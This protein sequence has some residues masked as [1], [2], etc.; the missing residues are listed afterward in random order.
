MAGGA[1]WWMRRAGSKGTTWLL[2]SGISL[3]WCSSQRKATCGS[4]TSIR[5]WEGLHQL[6]WWSRGKQHPSIFLWSICIL[7]PQASAS[8]VLSTTSAGKADDWLGQTVF[9]KR[10]LFLKNNFAGAESDMGWS[11]KSGYFASLDI[12]TL[13]FCNYV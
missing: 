9:S 8:L 11:L 13:M 1:V 6:S 7:S 10:K 4:S 3:F 2:L 12:F 5:N